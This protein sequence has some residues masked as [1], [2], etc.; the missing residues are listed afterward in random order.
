MGDTRAGAE[1]AL[2]PNRGLP[3]VVDRF[4]LEGLRGAKTIS[5]RDVIQAASAGIQGVPSDS[6]GGT[7][8]V[9]PGT[10]E[11]DSIRVMPGYSGADP[12]HSP[13]GTV[14]PH[15]CGWVD[16]RG[17]PLSGNKGSW[18]TAVWIGRP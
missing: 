7:I 18:P 3:D 10:K 15:H 16:V 4:D 2:P 9:I 17:A 6:G 14:C 5:A 8:F 12:H 13:L 11:S 1:L